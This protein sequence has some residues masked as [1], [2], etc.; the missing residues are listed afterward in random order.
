VAELGSILEGRFRPGH[1]RG[2]ATVVLKLLT[3]VPGAHYFSRRT[4]SRE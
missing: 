1:F 3:I 2:V 4:R